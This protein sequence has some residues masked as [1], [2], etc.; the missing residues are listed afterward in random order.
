MAKHFNL[1]ITMEDNNKIIHK[2]FQLD[3]KE[4]SIEIQLNFIIKKEVV[5]ISNIQIH[6]T[7]VSQIPKSPDFEEIGNKAFLISHHINTNGKTVFTRIIGN[8]YANDIT[9]EILKLKKEL[10]G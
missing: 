5:E 4:G 1:D 10:S 8:N 9:E 2:R 3:Y 7:F 6:G